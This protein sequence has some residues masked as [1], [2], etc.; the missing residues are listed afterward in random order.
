[1]SKRNIAIVV[2]VVACFL[3]IGVIVIASMP[4]DIQVK[5]IFA[6]KRFVERAP[7]T[8]ANT[9]EDRWYTVSEYAGKHIPFGV[10]NFLSGKPYS[11]SN[12]GIE[13]TQ[14]QWNYVNGDWF[15]W[16]SAD[17]MTYSVRMKNGLVNAYKANNRWMPVDMI[18]TPT[19][20][21]GIIRLLEL[22]I[23]DGIL[24]T[25]IMP[26]VN[27]KTKEVVFFDK[28]TEPT[29]FYMNKV[30]AVSKS[31]PNILPTKFDSISKSTLDASVKTASTKSAPV[32]YGT[33]IGEMAPTFSMNMLDGST[34]NLSNFYGHK[35]VLNIWATWCGICITEFP[36]INELYTNNK[37]I[38]VLAV[39]ADGSP[40]QIQRIK[41]KYD[42]RYPC[43]FTMTSAIGVD[44]LYAARGF[45]TTYFLDE[46]GVIRNIKVGGFSNVSE[47]QSILDSIN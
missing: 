24:N 3:I 34:A 12:I 32:I 14:D 44:K 25:A 26:F 17:G 7:V 5:N 43:D 20:G 45:P 23:F 2:G 18:Y 16:Q 28:E 10:K 37:N 31:K 1:M 36:V 41:D 11:L 21:Y 30:G 46:Y 22:M 38:N 4:K 19:Y 47:I 15:T 42:T 40:K 35:T 29:D 9:I 6:G 39:C 8:V 27:D 33:K 13:E